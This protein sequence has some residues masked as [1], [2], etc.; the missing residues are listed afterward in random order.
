MLQFTAWP[1]ESRAINQ[2][3]GENRYFDYTKLN[4]K[5]PGHEG[6]DV[7][8]A[9]GTKIYAVAAGKVEEVG[10]D[11]SH[12]Y[13]LHVRIRHSGGYLTV[14]AHLSEIDVWNGQEIA[15]GQQLGLA[16]STGNSTGPH[17]HLTL[18]Q[19]GAEF[20]DQHGRW[21]Y[22]IINP[23]P[24]LLPL[25]GVNKPAGPYVNGWA[26]VAAVKVQG[27]IA[28][29]T[30]VINLRAEPSISAGLVGMVPTGS[31]MIVTGAP[32]GNN[33]F[34][35][36][37]VQV[38]AV[39]ITQKAQ[40][41]QPTPPPSST[42]PADDEVAAWAFTS[43]VTIR[44]GVA[45]AGKWGLNLRD[46][47]RRDAGRV[48]I[49]PE[50]VQ[51]TVTGAAQ[52]EYTPILVDSAE[53][54]P[55]SRSAEDDNSL[56]MVVLSAVKI[57]LCGTQFD[58]ASYDTARA[59]LVM[60]QHDDD[61]DAL[62]QLASE[63]E[64]ATWW[65]ANAGV[66]MPDAI[67]G[68]RNQVAHR[69]VIAEVFD[70]TQLDEARKNLIA[71][72]VVVNLTRQLENWSTFGAADGV[73]MR[74]PLVMTDLDRQSILSWVEDAIAKTR[75]Q[76]NW[77]LI[78]SSP[79]QTPMQI[80]AN[81]LIFWGALQHHPVVQGAMLDLRGRSADEMQQVAAVIGAR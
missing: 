21:P 62:G 81:F 48:G 17:L 10:N 64:T 27:E 45:T 32:Q 59:D 63:D 65:F 52:G 71:A 15:A 76:P 35:Y 29:A 61:F 2:Y 75:Y 28:Q 53:V 12:P 5:L 58:R 46:A 40:T 74:L 7:R 55:A 33:Q 3:F 72:D 14:Y 9:S 26:Y 54:F 41:K 50:G 51:M 70:I 68:L 57:G 11:A 22:N 49:V 78:Q 42:P 30:T 56:D 43:G 8:A 47:P 37:P 44:N 77:L 20:S 66:E 80:A 24:F 60:V 13:G 6:I 19:D 4:E 1:T 34:R 16:G 67:G 39:A 25:L 79:E 38:P 73:V 69:P 31:T 36:F 18:K 23:E